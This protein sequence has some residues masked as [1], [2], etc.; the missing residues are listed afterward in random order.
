MNIEPGRQP[1]PAASADHQHVDRIST[2]TTIFV[3]VLL[4]VTVYALQWILLP[5]V[6]AGLIAYICTPA[7][8]RLANRTRLPRALFA[9]LVFLALLSFG[10]LVGLLGFP[11][12]MQEL[13]HLVTDLQGTIRQLAEAAIG[14]G[15]V[16][17]FGQSMNAQQLAHAAVAG[18]RDWIL[19]AGRIA[20]IGGV[21]FASVFGLFLTLVL[22]FYFLLSGPAIMAGLLWLVPPKER[23]LVR[24]VWSRL[25][26]V[27]KRY[28][29]GVIAVVTYAAAAAYIG[30]GLVL[31]IPHAVF[32]ALLT[33]VLEM[34]PM[35]GPGAAAVIAGLVAVRYAA[36]IGPIIAYAVYAAAL[37]LSIDQLFG[38][39]ALG[40]ASRC[41][42]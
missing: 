26:P 8:E 41:I 39:L 17:V 20:F 34:I 21:A 35:I 4:V 2:Q 10:S 40:S 23:L 30:L 18:I 27:L 31:G 19:Q 42:R 1:P 33:G 11:P 6:I 9:A 12:L 36:G 25:D 29:I 38:P 3:L 32:L 13:T 5:F 22:L 7:L 24:H 37:R 15:T 16:T 14:H 28:F